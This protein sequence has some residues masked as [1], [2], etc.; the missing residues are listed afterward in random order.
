MV[1]DKNGTVKEAPIFRPAGPGPRVGLCVETLERLLGAEQPQL[2]ARAST[3]AVDWRN[4]ARTP[5]SRII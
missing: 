4:M 1:Q 2:V 5:F 3:A